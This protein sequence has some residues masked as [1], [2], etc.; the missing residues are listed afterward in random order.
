[1]G[2]LLFGLTALGTIPFFAF[3]PDVSKFTGNLPPAQ[4]A[5]DR[6]PQATTSIR[7][8]SPVRQ[9]TRPIWS[10]CRLT[11]LC[12]RRDRRRARHQPSDTHPVTPIAPPASLRIPSF[13]DN[14]RSR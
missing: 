9:T 10:V 13:Q 1:V 3:V 6:A 14:K 11:S 12:R 7:A 2:I 4:L 8:S 5:D